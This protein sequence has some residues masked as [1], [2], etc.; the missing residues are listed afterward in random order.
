MGVGNAQCSAPAV[1]GRRHRPASSAESVPELHAGSIFELLVAIEAVV[2]A[3]P[4][5]QWQ[6]QLAQDAS[7]TGALTRIVSGTA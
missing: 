1:L 3:V 2:I 4:G 6:R 7:V 5:V